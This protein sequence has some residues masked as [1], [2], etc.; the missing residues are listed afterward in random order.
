MGYTENQQKAIDH[1]S[2]NVLV[3]AGAGS[4]KTS[5]L[6]EHVLSLLNDE[7]NPVNIDRLLIVTFTK[8]AAAEIRGRITNGIKDRKQL[9]LISHAHISTIDSF[10]AWIVKNNFENL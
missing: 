5:V 9:A 6:T 3:S 7:N 8:A 10:C 2:G 1:R 4:G